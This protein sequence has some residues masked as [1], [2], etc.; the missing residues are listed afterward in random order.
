MQAVEA[1]AEKDA[2]RRDAYLYQCDVFRAIKRYTTDERERERLRCL[3]RNCLWDA[4]WL[5]GYVLSFKADAP[6]FAAFLQASFQ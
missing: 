1:K 3:L 5:W 4:A 6:E 2:A